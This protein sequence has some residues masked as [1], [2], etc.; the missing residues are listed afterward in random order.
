MLQS[1]VLSKEAQKLGQMGGFWGKKMG[2]NEARVAQ[3]GII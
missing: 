3:T 1:P 2:T